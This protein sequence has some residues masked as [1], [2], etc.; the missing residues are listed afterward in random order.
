MKRILAVLLAFIIM[1]L[2]LPVYASDYEGHWAEKEIGYLVENGIVN[3]DAQGVRPEAYITRAEFAAVINRNFNFKTPASEGFKDIS[4]KDWYYNDMLFAKEAGYMVGDDN[5]YCNPKK[6]ITR[7]EAA[8]IYYRLLKP[9]TKETKTF[10]DSSDIPSWAKEA[11]NALCSAGIFKGYEDGSFK[12]SNSIKRAEAFYTIVQSQRFSSDKSTVKEEITED[13]TDTVVVGGGSGSTGGG[14]GGGGFS[15]GGGGGGGSLGGSTTPAPVSVE[16]YE[17]NPETKIA[18]WYAVSNAEGYTFK[19]ERITEGVPATAPVETPVSGTEYNFAADVI[20]L[21]TNG[22]VINESF[23]VSVAATVNSVSY[24][25]QT[26]EISVV[27]PS[28]QIPTDFRCEQTIN[29]DQSETIKI[30]FTAPE[31]SDSYKLEIDLGDGFED[32]NGNT[33]D[34]EQIDKLSKEHQIRYQAFTNDAIYLDS[35]IHTQTLRFPMFDHDHER[36]D[37]E[38]KLI[39]NSR[40]FKNMTLDTTG[41]YELSADLTGDYKLDNSYTAINFSGVLD[42]NGHEIQIERTLSTVTESY[43]GGLFNI[44]TDKAEIKNLTVSGYFNVPG[45]DAGKTIG[46]IV[47]RVASSAAQI[48]NVVNNLSVNASNANYVGGIA[49]DTMGKITNSL[50]TG[51]VT[52]KTY[53]GGIAGQVSAAATE[54]SGL[55]NRGDIS[56]PSAGGIFGLARYVFSITDSYN[57]GSL[58]GTRAF[59][60]FAYLHD[61]VAE[62]ADGTITIS[63]CYSKE[64]AALAPEE[65]SLGAN[66]PSKDHLS[67]A[68]ENSYIS[69]DI[70]TL[71]SQTAL[72]SAGWEFYDASLNPEGLWI[73]DETNPGYPY[74]QI[75]NMPYEA[76]CPLAM[77]ADGY[78]LIHNADDFNA[79]AEVSLSGNYRIV[80]DFAADDVIDTSIPSFSGKIIGWDEENGVATNRTIYIELDAGD[81][82]A[83]EKYLALFNSLAA[84]ADISYLTIEGSVT[85]GTEVNLGGFVS[86]LA[87]LTAA[88]TNISNIIN[89]ATIN[90]TISNFSSGIVGH[91]KGN[92][93]NCTNNGTIQAKV[94]VGGI[95]A[96]QENASSQ[97][98]NLTNT[99]VLNRV[100][101]TSYGGGIV[102]LARFGFNIS[103]SQNSGTFNKT[104]NNYGMIG[105][106]HTSISGDITITGCTTTGGIDLAPESSKIIVTIN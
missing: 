52:A 98:S 85:A 13:N 1:S 48:S 38:V 27:N 83:D 8:T 22:K 36:G 45:A 54:F 67:I 23:K 5:G 10:T 9:E 47:G 92:V 66:S 96:Q 20:S 12:A 71:K 75:K 32:V 79:I 56:A 7:A 33:L 94:Y 62:T 49:G 28:V 35:A 106:Y 2:S 101:S 51:S 42:G 19:I 50:N 89:N 53:G 104:T 61:K 43:N 82:S 16:F 95:I 90:N 58:T 99:G 34:A 44:L 68:I 84:S 72:E 37:E 59:G 103:N 4:E 6:N 15:G 31:H 105:F 93:T 70:T 17:I 46:G 88:G 91:N 78:Y 69:S 21:M 30:T 39:A 29:Q 77:D 81:V 100:N 14:G 97:L 73:Y 80:E 24:S 76:Y 3:G 40:H 65:T 74:P 26:E 25:S 55:V 18:K 11:V 60:I 63:K 57:S 102:A 64:G 87:G 86:A 41:K